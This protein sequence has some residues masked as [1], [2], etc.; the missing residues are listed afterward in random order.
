MFMP[1]IV[2]SLAEKEAFVAKLTYINA[3]A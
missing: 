1:S 3:S 2:E